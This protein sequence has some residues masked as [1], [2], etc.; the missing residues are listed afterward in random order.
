[1]TAETALSLGCVLL[2]STIVVFQTQ[3]DWADKAVAQLPDEKLHI[4]LDA[5]TNSIAVI[6]K[7][8]AGNL[9]SRWTDFLSTDGEKPWRNRDDEFVDTF[10]SRQELIDSW[11]CGWNCVFTALHSLTAE[12]LNKTVTIRGQ[13][14]SVPLAMQRSLTHTAYHTGQILM[15]ARIL[16]GENWQTI[17]IPRGASS[18]FN[19]KV[20]GKEHYGR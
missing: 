9:A 12:D 1:M 7:H 6:M 20:W 14:H 11:E 10:Q 13:P 3:K 2:E 19:A 17:T 5:Q 18:Q 4:S 15:I 16:A 8:V